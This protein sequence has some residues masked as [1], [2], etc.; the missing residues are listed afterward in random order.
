MSSGRVR[1]LYDLMDSAYDAPQIAQFSRELGHVPIID[2]NPRRG[3][4]REFEPAHEV[5][6]CE[7]SSAERVKSLLKCRY[8]G[9]WVRVRGGVKV[10]SHLMF[11]IIA[12]T[13]ASLMARLV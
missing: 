12:L 4:K 11:G 8:G 9:R 6:Y 3:E 7:R 1:T 2:H 10:M 13:A 5:R